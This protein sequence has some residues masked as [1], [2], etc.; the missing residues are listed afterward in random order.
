MDL[1]QRAAELLEH[2][3]A[4][5]LVV[6]E[7][8]RSSIGQLHAAQDQFVFRRN[9]IGRQQCARRMASRDV[10]DGRHLSLLEPL[11][12]QRLVAAAAQGQRESIE[13]DRFSGAGLAGER[14]KAVG[15]IDVEPLDQND[16]ANGQSGEHRNSALQIRHH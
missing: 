14:G 9:V 3:H 10:E 2:L 16:V 11:P 15:K 4:D 13:Q 12:D 8:A 1:D 6:D 7:C 5:R